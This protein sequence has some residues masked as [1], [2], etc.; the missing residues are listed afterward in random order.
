MPTVVKN[1]KE[2]LFMGYFGPIGAGAVFYLEHSRHLFPKIGQG[3]G[4]ETD[5]AKAI[6]PV[7]YRLLLFSIIVH[8][9]SISALSLI[10]HYMGV[11]PIQEDAV[12]IRRVSIRV[13]TPSNSIPGDRDSCIA[14]NSFSRPVFD[15]SSLPVVKDRFD[16]KDDDMSSDRFSKDVKPDRPPVRYKL[17]PTASANLKQG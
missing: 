14:Y 16:E 17:Y 15:P 10:Y 7:V 5:L 4:E 9:L 2:A 6:G 8:W 13:A 1:W 12:E 11:K 3:D